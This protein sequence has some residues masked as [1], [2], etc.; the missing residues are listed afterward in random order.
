MRVPDGDVHNHS[1][2]DP[3]T[4]ASSSTAGPS[5]LG[6]DGLANGHNNGT[7][8]T[9]GHNGVQKGSGKVARVV[10]PGTLLYEDLSIDREEYVRLVLQSLRDVGYTCVMLSFALWLG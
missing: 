7:L 9:N 2:A 5:S 4:L 6:L 1:S 3:T 8:A 10:I